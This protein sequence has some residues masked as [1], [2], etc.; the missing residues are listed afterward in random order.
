MA[1]RRNP[2]AA[3]TKSSVVDTRTD[4]PPVPP[5][6]RVARRA[7]GVT[8]RITVHADQAHAVATR[9]LDLVDGLEGLW[10]RFIPSSDICRLNAAG[11][12]PVW[13]DPLTRRLIAHMNAGMEATTGFYNPTLLPLQVEDGDDRSLVDDRRCLIH[14]S[15]RPFDDMTGIQ[16]LDDGRVRLPAGM[17]LDAGGIGKGF[18]ADWICEQATGMG[19]DAV[20]VNLGGDLRVSGPM[21]DGHGWDI[22]VL[23]PRDLRTHTDTVCIATGGV[24][25][26]AIGARR[27]HGAPG[28][29][30]ILRNDRVADASD[31]IGAT[32]ASS[33]AAWSEVWAKYAVL[34]HPD[35]ALRT[36]DDNG[37]AVLLVATDGSTR[38]N[39][40]WEEL[41]P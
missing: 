12:A 11:G 18:A 5:V 17:T 40:A 31:T 32:V 16:F 2:P 1:A 33:S 20:C 19:A 3:L 15:A 37:L 24:A 25:T 36:F 14:P 35:T 21:P 7:M 38:T 28:E 9:C 29:S 27:L 41:R 34:A 13:V 23:D 26:S 22:E 39:R 6:A 10:S 30:H 8:C 4:S